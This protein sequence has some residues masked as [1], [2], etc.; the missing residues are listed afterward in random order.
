MST[1]P[2]GLGPLLT[3]RAA[4]VLLM[5]GVVGL[6]AGGLAYLAGH[7]VPTA[8]LVASGA[9]GSG[10]RLF[11]ALIA[12]DDEPHERWEGD[13]GTIS[14]ARSHRAVTRTRHE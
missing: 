12:A 11:H 9:V 6:V 4:V 1:A 8:V 10:L 13:M 2:P 7:D 5:A 3:V 14:R